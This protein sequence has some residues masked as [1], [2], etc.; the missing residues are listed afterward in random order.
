M[1]S[2]RVILASSDWKDVKAKLSKLEPKDKGDWLGT[3]PGKKP[4]KM[5]KRV[6]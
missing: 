3:A 6:R 2:T 1:N 5:K 4:R